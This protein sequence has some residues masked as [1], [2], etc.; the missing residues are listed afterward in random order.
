MFRFINRDTT[1][2]LK[3]LITGISKY[4]IMGR[5]IELEPMDERRNGEEIMDDE[6]RILEEDG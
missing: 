1:E 6:G 4:T 2:R 5:L 3:M